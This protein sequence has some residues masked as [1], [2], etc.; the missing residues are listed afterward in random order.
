[1]RP[2]KSPEDRAADSERIFAAMARGRRGRRAGAETSLAVLAVEVTRLH[3]ET[4]AGMCAECRMLM[5]C[6]TT[7]AVTDALSDQDN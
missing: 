4:D 5:P 1:M 7:E 6:A 3:R 2:D